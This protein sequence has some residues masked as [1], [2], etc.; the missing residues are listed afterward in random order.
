MFSMEDRAELSRFAQY[1]T[2]YCL[3][4]GKLKDR[5]YVKTLSCVKG[6]FLQ[7]ISQQP[8]MQLDAVV[9]HIEQAENEPWK[10]TYILDYQGVKLTLHANDCIFRKH[11]PIGTHKQVYVK[12][13]KDDCSE[14]RVTEK[15]NECLKVESFNNIPLIIPDEKVMDFQE[16]MKKRSCDECYDDWYIGPIDTENFSGENVKCQLGQKIVFAAKYITV[17]SNAEET[18]ILQFDHF[19]LDEEKFSCNDIFVALEADM[20]ACNIGGFSSDDVGD[21]LNFYLYLVTEFA[22]QLKIKSNQDNVLFFNQWSVIMQRLVTAKEQNQKDSIGIKILEAERVNR[23]VIDEDD[24]RKVNV[25]RKKMESKSSGRIRYFFCDSSGEKQY[26][27]FGEE[28]EYVEI[29]GTLPKNEL[30]NLA[31]KLRIY[32]ENIPYPELQQRKALENFRMG[33]VVN[34]ELKETIL[35]LPRADFK[36]T[37]IRVSTLQNVSI[38]ANEKQLESVIKAMAVKDIFMIQGPPGTGKTTVIKEIIWQQL[39]LKAESRIL[40][41]SQAN[42]AVDNVLRGLPAMGISEQQLVRCG[43]ESKI[44]DDLQD[45]HFDQQVENYSKELSDMPCRKDLQVYRTQWIHLLHDKDTRNRVGEYMLQNFDVVG[46]T[47][48]GLAKKQF[49]LDSLEFDLV[50]IDE[51]GKALPGEL[52]LPINRARKVIII[53]DHKQLPPVID[54]ALYDG[55]VDTSDILDEDEDTFY[56]TSLFEKLYESCPSTNKCMLNKQF[57]MPVVIGELI[58]HLFYDSQLT[59]ATSCTIKKPLC[60]ENNLIFMNMEQDDTY[61][62]QT[63]IVHSTG[64][65]TISRRSGP[66]NLREIE[67]VA[68]LVE[69]IRNRYQDRIV[70]ITPYK[71]QKKRIWQAFKSKHIDNKVYVNTIDA[72]QGDE[73]D[74]VIYCM[75]RAKKMT[76]YFSDSARLNVAFSRTRNMLFIIGSIAYLKQYGTEHPLYYIADYLAEK[77]RILEYDIVLDSTFDWQWNSQSQQG[78]GIDDAVKTTTSNKIPEEVIDKLFMVSGED[79]ARTGY[80][81]CKCCHKEFSPEELIE[82]Y[83]L[84]CLDEGENYQ[85]RGCGKWMRYTNEQKYIFKQKKKLYCEDCEIVEEYPCKRCGAIIRLKNKDYKEIQLGRKRKNEYCYKCHN[86]RNE[87]VIV[88]NCQCCGKKITLKKGKIED[89]KVQGRSLPIYCYEC[90]QYIFVGKC[91]YC[92]KDIKLRKWYIERLKAQGKDIDL[93]CYDCRN[94]PY[95]TRY[96]TECGRSFVITN[97]EKYSMDKKGYEL[98]KKCK[99]CLKNRRGN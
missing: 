85:C 9:E 48:V 25:F 43:D 28:N 14:V 44:A 32:K 99:S 31:Y 80:I 76:K 3:V 33:K 42:V 20:H 22:K 8:N 47:C 26:I 23:W 58:S 40:V 69:K 93:I 90:N 91:Q 55:T 51:A 98:P 96:C 18:K 83:C 67:I 21:A 78:T 59:S 41:V 84:Q 10:I 71:N 19:L 13:C 70:I 88:G 75:T 2:I 97:G 79:E 81:K 27:K 29:Q 82:G 7:Q 15:Y 57:R 53:G 1:E 46:A 66:Y 52:L 86:E 45:Y 92:G 56:N 30:E 39:K 49:G 24:Y 36:D 50:I 12:W 16:T 68:S 64:I 5:T 6:M 89:W 65:S 74:I 38:L 17:T 63:D 54:A 35:D 73:A 72:F 77:G 4:T 62:E 37:G 94:K 11:V 61:K 60:L 87:D 34:P 95:E